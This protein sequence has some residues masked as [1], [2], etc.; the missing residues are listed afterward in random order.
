MPGISCR[1]TYCQ[2]PYDTICIRYG[3]QC[4]RLYIMTH[5]QIRILKTK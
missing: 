2:E 5:I 1:S 4:N 3:A